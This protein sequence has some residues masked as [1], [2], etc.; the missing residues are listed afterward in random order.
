MRHWPIG[1]LRYQP[2]S[3]IPLSISQQIR[4]P[5]RQNQSANKDVFLLLKVI[6]IIIIKVRVMYTSNWMCVCW[7]V[8]LSRIL[9]SVCLRQ[10]LFII[11]CYYVSCLSDNFVV[12]L[13]EHAYTG[14][15]PDQSKQSVRQRDKIEGR[16]EP[17]L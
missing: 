4:R 13:N 6:R 17:F 10:F 15:T 1:Q 11:I 9:L 2:A 7:P 16:V 5:T 12:S 8:C 3:S 14:K